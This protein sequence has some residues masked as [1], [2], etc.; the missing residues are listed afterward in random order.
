DGDWHPSGVVVV[1][2]ETYELAKKFYDSPEY[3]AVIKQRFDSADSAVIIAE[4]A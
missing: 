4:S 3:Q 2:F 1:E